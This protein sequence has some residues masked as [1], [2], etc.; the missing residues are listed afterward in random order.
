M[1][2]EITCVYQDCPLC[3]ARGDRLKKIVEVSGVKLRKVSFASPEG[4]DLVHTAVFEKGIKTMPFFVL[5]GD[6]AASVEALLVEKPKAAKPKKCT[7]R[8]RKAKKSVQSVK[9]GAEN[10]VDD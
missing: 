9:K 7:K 5:D 6:F 1:L 8:V 4:K 10:G 3:G 2:K